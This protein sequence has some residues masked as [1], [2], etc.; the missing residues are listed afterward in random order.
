MRE[1][2][3]RERVVATLRH[4]E[5][6]RVPMDLT[7]TLGAYTKLVK[8]LEMEKV[9]DSEPKIANWLTYV[10]VDQ[11][12]L[13]ALD[14]DIVHLGSRPPNGY[15]KELPDGTL[16]DEWGVKRRKIERPG[17]GFYLEMVENP[18]R[19]ATLEDLDDYPWPNPHDPTVTEGLVDRIK[20]WYDDTDY[21]IQV[22]LE[23]GNWGE[24][25]GYLRGIEQWWTDVV[26]NKPFAVALMNKLAD[27]AIEFNRVCIDLIGKYVQIIR[28][29]G[30]DLGGQDNPI[31]SPKMVDTMFKPVLK[32]QWT[33]VKSFFQKVNPDGKI[34]FHT[35]GSVYKLIPIFVESGLDIL[36]P[37]QTTAAGM[38]ME[39]IKKEFGDKLVFHGAMDIQQI[40]PFSTVDQVK[41]EVKLRIKQLAP[42][43]GFILAPAH[44]FQD[45][46]PPE[47]IVAMYRAGKEYGRYPLNV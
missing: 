8:Y 33:T 35:C 45:D 42:G 29:T 16:V 41:E 21:A 37:L 39:K 12:V 9:V 7:I 15:P 46:T 34:F 28:F 44:A 13:K 43:G 40:M 20:G 4:Q 23:R 24:Q 10:P 25:A 27:I 31:F 22:W 17:G 11:K 6:D 26:V 5:P 38:D 3:S 18:L 1:M 19:D 32:R 2:T 30:W 14:I 36:D 47:N